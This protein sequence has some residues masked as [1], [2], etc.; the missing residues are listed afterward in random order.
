MQ[1][2]M[3]VHD[4]RVLQGVVDGHEVVI[5]HHGQEKVIQPC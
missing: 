1:N 3:G 5:G 4:D 2:Q